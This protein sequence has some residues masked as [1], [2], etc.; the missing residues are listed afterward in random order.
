ME[1]VNL[2]GA[3]QVVAAGHNIAHAAE[4]MSQA[5]SSFGYALEQHQRALEEHARA[6]TADVELAALTALVQHEAAQTAKE[7]A[8]SGGAPT[9]DTEAT[10]ALR[11]LLHERGLL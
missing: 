8:T 2:V 10:A 5:A 6:F 1:Y 4:T 7:V 9:G 3:E 11:V